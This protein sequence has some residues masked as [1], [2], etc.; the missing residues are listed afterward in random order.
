MLIVGTLRL[1]SIN[2]DF[3]ADDERTQ[4]HRSSNPLTKNRPLLYAT[5]IVSA[6]S[7]VWVCSG[8]WSS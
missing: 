5:W 2:C 4:F 6:T 7:G 3:R 1:F 8:R